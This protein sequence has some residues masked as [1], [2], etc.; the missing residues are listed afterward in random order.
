M[1]ERGQELLQTTQPYGGNVMGQIAKEHQE[2]LDLRVK[3]ENQ[4]IEI[5]ELWERVKNAELVLSVCKKDL[6]KAQRGSILTEADEDALIAAGAVI[7]FRRKL[8]GGRV[9]KIKARGRD[10]SSARG[11]D[12]KSILKEAVRKAREWL[13]R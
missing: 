6:K 11:P 7:E 1:P 10:A 4:R 9:I 2:L 8:H 5:G 13:A 3:C 12:N